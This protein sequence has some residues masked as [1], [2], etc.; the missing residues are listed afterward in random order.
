MR[1]AALCGSQLLPFSLAAQSVMARVLLAPAPLAACRRIE[2]NGPMSLLLGQNAPSGSPTGNPSLTRLPRLYLSPVR[3]AAGQS[4][5][6][7]DRAVPRRRG[8]ALRWHPFPYLPLLF[9]LPS[10]PS[11]Y[12]RKRGSWRLWLFWDRRPSGP[13]ADVREHLEGEHASVNR[14]GGGAL[15]PVRG[16]FFFPMTPLDAHGNRAERRGRR[17][18]RSLPASPRLKI[19]EF[20]SPVFP[21]CNFWVGFLG[22]VGI[23]G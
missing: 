23:S 16:W 13:V 7:G 5:T 4:T 10:S 20:F 21:L 18:R 9:F 14:L 11:T 19:G 6:A 3:S 17:R 12:V 15:F 22:V 2:S 1:A 8:R